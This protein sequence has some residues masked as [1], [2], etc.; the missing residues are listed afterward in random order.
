MM[1]TTSC[2]CVCVRYYWCFYSIK[3]HFTWYHRPSFTTRN[4]IREKNVSFLWIKTFPCLFLLFGRCRAHFVGGLKYKII[5]IKIC[6]RMLRGKQYIC[7]C[8]S[9]WMN[10]YVCY[11]VGEIVLGVRPSNHF[12]YYSF[13]SHSLNENWEHSHSVFFAFHFP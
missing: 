11:S 1:K 4:E 7:I 8:M 5:K 13:Y 10:F 6:W 2:K 3:S 12:F 9:D